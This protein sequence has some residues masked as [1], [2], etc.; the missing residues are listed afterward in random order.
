[1]VKKYLMTYNSNVNATRDDRKTK[2]FIDFL[3]F[4]MCKFFSKYINIRQRTVL[5]T[6]RDGF[7]LSSSSAI[8]YRILIS[9]LPT[10]LQ[11]SPLYLDVLVRLTPAV[12]SAFSATVASE[13]YLKQDGM[14]RPEVCGLVQINV[15]IT[16]VCWPAKVFGAIILL[17]MA[18]YHH[19]ILHVLPKAVNHSYS[20]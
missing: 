5:H 12:I 7:S 11:L 14:K 19:Q 4:Y 18:D 20:C 6:P 16:V 10:I 9:T 13:C 3:F 15:K 2:F 8:T 17:K 1:M